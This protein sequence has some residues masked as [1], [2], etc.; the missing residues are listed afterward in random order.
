M[1]EVELGSIDA[2]SMEMVLD[3]TTIYIYTCIKAVFNLFF[4]HLQ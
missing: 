3:S 4:R 2:V 1:K